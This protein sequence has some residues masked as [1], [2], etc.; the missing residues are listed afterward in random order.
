MQHPTLSDHE[1]HDATLIAGHA[2]G[3]S[4]DADRVRAE[5]L[6][7]D[8]TACADLRRDLTAIAAATR[9]LP[10]PA[11]LSRDLRLSPEQAARLRRGS[12]LRAFLRPFGA[13]RSAVRPMAAAFTSLGLVGLLVGVLLPGMMLT[14]GAP[15]AA[16]ELGRDTAVGAP[17]ATSAAAQGGTSEAPGVYPAAASSGR[18]Q[19]AQR[20]AVPDEKATDDRAEFVGPDGTAAALG[21]EVAGDTG[22]DAEA[23][24]TPLTSQSPSPII[25]GSLALLG[26]GL[27]LFG[28][29]I[30]S[31]RVR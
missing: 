8:C 14:A 16:P 4:S 18:L 6:L 2:A 26:I 27:L 9:S 20:T 23:P 7:A 11:T 25:A 19:E 5:A 13:T 28:L 17:A 29:R 10:A 31:G 21:G 3:D 30:A 22:G 15:A 24:R 1:R 12:W